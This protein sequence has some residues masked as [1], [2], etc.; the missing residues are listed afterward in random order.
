MNPES[1]MVSLYPPDNDFLG[2]TIG[3]G[4]TK[5]F[6]QISAK[7]VNVPAFPALCFS[8]CRLLLAA[9]WHCHTLK[10]RIHSHYCF[11]LLTNHCISI[12]SL[13]KVKYRILAAHFEE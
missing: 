1:G 13:I 12:F 4:P 10:S 6:H 7:S 3:L 9:S 11:E 8:T 2:F 5:I